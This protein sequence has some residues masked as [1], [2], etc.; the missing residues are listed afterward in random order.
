MALKIIDYG[1]PQY[2]QMVRLRNEILRHPL[3]MELEEDDIVADR[4]YILIGAF[5]DD[6]MLGCCLLAPED[7]IKVVLRQMAVRPQLQGKGIGK[8]LMDFAEAIARDSG[9]REILMHARSTATGFYERMGYMTSGDIFVKLSI[10]H[11]LMSKKI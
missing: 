11:I 2:E 8:A 4:D 9:Y 1:S 3:G 7:E 10:P 5:E 6:K